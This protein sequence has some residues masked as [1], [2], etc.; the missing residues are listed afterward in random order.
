MN[1]DYGIDWIVFKEEKVSNVLILNLN[2]TKSLTLKQAGSRTHSRATYP[3]HCYRWEGQIHKAK[4]TGYTLNAA[5]GLRVLFGSLWQQAYLLFQPQDEYF[6]NGI[7]GVSYILVY[8]VHYLLKVKKVTTV[9]MSIR[10]STQWCSLFIGALSIASYLACTRGS[11]ES[12]LSQAIVRS[13]RD[14]DQFIR[15]FWTD[16]GRMVGKDFW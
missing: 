13:T 6:L 12:E 2:G 10:N 4:W 1:N 14:L 11:K 3:R 16:H 15:E 5:I 7:C 9:D 8:D